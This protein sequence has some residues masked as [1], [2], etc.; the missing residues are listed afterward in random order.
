MFRIALITILSLFFVTPVF[1]EEEGEE[2]A[3]PKIVYHEL[4]PSFVTNIQSDHRDRHTY[5]LVK[6]EIM[7]ENQKVIDELRYHE[8]QIRD[9]L[10]M[11]F[12]GQSRQGLE[13]S[14][15]KTK[16]QAKALETVRNVLNNESAKGEHIKRVLFTQFTIE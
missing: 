16:L 1:A 9:H 13:D 10:I 12:A 6:V 8:P 4:H 7:G 11:L 3:G 2:G 14:Q 5:V 15:G